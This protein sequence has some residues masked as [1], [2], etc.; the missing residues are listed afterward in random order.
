MDK[1]VK[2]V[3]ECA[4][5]WENNNRCWYATN[6]K[7]IHENN[8]FAI[9]KSNLRDDREQKTNGETIE[10]HWEIDL[11]HKMGKYKKEIII[12]KIIITIRGTFQK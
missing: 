4:E 11:L 9:I 7:N 12:Q 3:R 5:R 1:Y 6:N 10:H 8:F 2:Y